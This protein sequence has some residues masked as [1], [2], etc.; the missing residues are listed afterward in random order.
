MELLAA[1]QRD[2]G[3][4]GRLMQV[5]MTLA[6]GWIVEAGQLASPQQY[7]DLVLGEGCFRS[8]RDV[9]CRARQTGD[10]KSV[11]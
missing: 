6:M 9:E 4:S 11:V 7:R 3:K 2:G 5:W 8:L 1:M 10:R